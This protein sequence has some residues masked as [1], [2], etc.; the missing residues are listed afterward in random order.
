VSRYNLSRSQKSVTV[1][2]FNYVQMRVSGCKKHYKFVLR[3]GAKAKS[4]TNNLPILSVL[5]VRSIYFKV[6]KQSDNLLG[7]NLNVEFL[8]LFFEDR[9]NG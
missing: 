9:T 2:D 8:F 6:L 4:M 1:Q 3:A 5:G 7:I